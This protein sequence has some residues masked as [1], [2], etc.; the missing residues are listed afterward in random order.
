VRGDSAAIGGAALAFASAAF[1]A[2]ATSRRSSSFS[3]GFFTKRKISPS[4]MDPTS[5]ARSA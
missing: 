5:E 3:H 1:T 4:L 2:S